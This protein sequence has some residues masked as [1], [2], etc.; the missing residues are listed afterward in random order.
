MTCKKMS[1]GLEVLLKESMH[2]PI[3]AFNVALVLESEHRSP[4][5]VQDY[6]FISAHGGYTPAMIKLAGLYLTGRILERADDMS[7]PQPVRN[8]DQGVMW[9]FRAANNED[10][11]AFYLLARCYFDGVGVKQNYKTAYS[12]LD[13]VT[14][15]NCH[16]NPYEGTEIIVFG[17]ASPEIEHYLRQH[18]DQPNP[19]SACAVFTNSQPYKERKGKYCKSIGF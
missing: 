7:Q 18:W 14:F 9:L 13:R 11:I 12:Y 16:A 2:N 17:S 5:N 1:E 4:M 8:V 10:E 19:P 6:L 15:P 3:A